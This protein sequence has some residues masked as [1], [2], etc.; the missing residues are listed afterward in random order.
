MTAIAQESNVISLKKAYHYS[1]NHKISKITDADE[2]MD[3]IYDAISEIMEDCTPQVSIENDGIGSY[4]YWGDKCYDAGTDYV[5]IE[6]NEEEA[7][8]LVIDISNI[9]QDQLKFAQRLTGAI[10][11]TRS[12]NYGGDEYSDGVDFDMHVHTETSMDIGS[13]SSYNVESK[14]NEIEYS[15]KLTIKC[16]WCNC[17]DYRVLV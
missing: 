5:L 15:C 16:E 12:D 10:N 17:D 3:E 8:N 4:E 13:F 7:M 14:R 6:G 11:V 1:L 9:D 2:L